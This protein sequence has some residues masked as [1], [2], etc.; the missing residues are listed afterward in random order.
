MW[1][2]YLLIG[3]Y[4]LLPFYKMVAEHSNG[5]LLKYLLAVYAVFLSLI[6]ILRIWDIRLGFTI[7]VSTIYPFYLFA[8]YAIYSGKVRI[9]RSTGLIMAIIG[10]LLTILFTAIRIAKDADS[11]EMFRDYNGINVLLQSVGVFAFVFGSEEPL[12]Q[13]QMISKVLTNLDENSFGIYLIHIILI[14]WLFR[15]KAFD[16]YTT[17]SLFVFIAIKL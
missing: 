9:S 10:S 2:P 1:Y 4:L 12:F 7:N 6:P 5:N 15:V 13:N 3:L 8:G 11:L 16:P 14:K 17:A